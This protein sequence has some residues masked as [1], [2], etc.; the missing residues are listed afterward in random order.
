MFFEGPEKKL[1]IQL[2]AT[3]TLNL[4][5]LDRSFWE[6]RVRESGAVIL[7]SVHN[8]HIDAFLL[9]ESSLFVYA[10]RIVMITCGRTNLATAASAMV[11]AWG[12]DIELLV[13][14]RKNEHFPEYQRTGFMD[15]ARALSRVIPSRAWRFGSADGHR[16]Q[17]LT[18]VRP[19]EAPND[20]RTLEILMHGIHPEA[21]RMFGRDR[22]KSD[23]RRREAFQALFTGFE[24]DEYY[25]E[26]TGYSL[27]AIRGDRYLT[28]HITPE[29]IASYVS[30]E[31]NLDFGVNPYPWVDK[32]RAVF[33]PQA[34]DVMTF[35]KAAPEAFDLEEH[36]RVG[37]AE[38]RLASGYH[39]AFRHFERIRD[40][41]DPAFELPL[42]PA[43]SP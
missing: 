40:R 13:Y 15:D 37:W 14:E 11:R 39:V 19:H 22:G 17:M 32:V 20:D 30:F 33:E 42:E 36:H 35:S 18:S 31:T 12:S 3:S 9:S 2:S 25:F 23:A 41:A 1:E 5:G 24:A 6:A 8:D 16:I 28:I 27:N 38:E 29:D 10:K 26:P 43:S 34:L 4:R 21:A 7:S